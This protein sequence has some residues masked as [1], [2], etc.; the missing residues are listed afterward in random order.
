MKAGTFAKEEI[1][2]MEGFL[3]NWKR[4]VDK[5]AIGYGHNER[6]GD[7]SW[8]HEP[9]TRSFADLILEKDLVIFEDILNKAIKIP[10]SQKQFDILILW[11]YNTGRSKSTL[12][13]LINQKASTKTITDWWKSHYITA[14]ESNP[15]RKAQL[16]AGLRKRRA[17]E[18]KLWEEEANRL[19][20]GGG[21]SSGGKL[22]FLALVA[23]GY[24][25]YRRFKK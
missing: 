17:E 20:S 1:K 24:Y 23:G 2:R 4:D 6:S 18:A 7:R 3:A 22:F 14:Q 12:F 8:I 15:V 10:L 21:T 9:I 16:E 25:L 19:A 5:L 13:D 11:V